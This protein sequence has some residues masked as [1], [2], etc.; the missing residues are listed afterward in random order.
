MNVRAILLA[1]C[2]TA[3]ACY[4]GARG[5]DPA[6]DGG[7][8]VGEAGTGTDEGGSGDDDDDPDVPA[9]CDGKPFFGPA[10]LRRM[11]ALQYRNTIADLFGGAVQPGADFPPTTIG[12]GYTNDPA[13]NV[14]SELAAEKIMLAAE[15]AGAQLVETFA[16]TTGCTPTDDACARTWTEALARRAFRRPLDA[17]ETDLLAALWDEARA[18]GD[19]A[20]TTGRV[21]TAALQ[22]PQ[23]LYL[24]DEGE[25]VPDRPGLLALSDHSIASRLSY[26]LW[27]STPDDALLAA[28]EAG[29]LHTPAQIETHALRLLDDPRAEPAVTRFYAEWLRT[30]TLAA[31]DKDS[32]AF[33]SFDDAMLTSMRAE[34]QRLV[35]RLHFEAGGSLT[36]LMTT[37]ETDV[38]AR[39]AE[40]YGVSAP[41]G[42]TRVDLSDQQRAGVL[43]LPLVLAA[44]SGPHTTRPIGRGLLVRNQ[45]LCE[46]MPPP[47]PAAM[48]EVEFPPGATEREKAALLLE[49]PAC[50]SCHVML[51]PVGLGLEH[52][53]AIGAYREEVD[54][55]PVDASGELVGHENGAFEGAPQLAERLLAT[56]KLDHC[57]AQQLV[58]YGFGKLVDDR[59]ECAI[60]ALTTTFADANHDLQSLLLAF[61]TSDAFRFRW[62]EEEG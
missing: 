13:N 39:L 21:I 53:D 5:S 16:T 3:S 60:D 57:L 14:V 26:L 17:A 15:D 8:D 46:T 51:N 35:R 19:A 22:M 33:P 6:G 52:Y 37:T 41:D 61:V 58:Q 56:G 42:W 11:T 25:P 27:D 45:F 4:T 47:P 12:L 9:E 31:D 23:F 36:D 59:D 48:G 1:L 50:R 44:A 55:A 7:E 18:E 10:P 49:D 34:L 32:D 30:A 2:T 38:D 43:T 24:V 40:L 29:E 54:G 20:T 28:A 62:L